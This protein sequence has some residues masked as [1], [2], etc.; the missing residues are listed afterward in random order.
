M[1]FPHP[2]DPMAMMVFLY[3]MDP[4]MFFLYPKDPIIM[5][6]F[7]CPMDSMMVFLYPMNPMMVFPYPMMVFPYGSYDGLSLSMAIF[8]TSGLLSCISSCCPLLLYS[9]D[10]CPSSFVLVMSLH[11]P[12]LCIC[13]SGPQYTACTYSTSVSADPTVSYLGIT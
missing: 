8:L 5:M 10:F 7:L 9:F 12:I 4:M 6:I 13:M 2:M 1:V 3:P 11:V